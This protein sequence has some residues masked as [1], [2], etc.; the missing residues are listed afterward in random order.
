MDRGLDEVWRSVREAL[1]TTARDSGPAIA[2]FPERAS[3][4][5]T[6]AADRFERASGARLQDRTVASADEFIPVPRPSTYV[7]GRD[8]IDEVDY[9]ALRQPKG[10]AASGSSPV[11]EEIQRLQGFDGH[12][13]FATREEIDAV[14]T[15]SRPRLFRGFEED[16]YLEAFLAG[17]LRSGGGT[18]GNGLYVTSLEKVALAYTHPNRTT[19][20]PTRVTRMAL[21]PEARVVKY[22]DIKSELTRVM[23]QV[24]RETRAASEMANPTDEDRARYFA[25]LDKRLT[26]GDIGQYGALRGYDA[27]E[28]DVMSNGEWNILNPTA[29]LIQR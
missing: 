5:L 28:S 3:G 24:D 6:E 15:K 25:L 1:G 11:F 20:D 22:R 17:S 27:I 10:T 14:V 16:S 13:T 18:T 8:L 2:A 23:A 12:F 29:L 7:P 26:F 21:H 4:H 19:V 9:A